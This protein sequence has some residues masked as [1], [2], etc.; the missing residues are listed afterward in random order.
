MAT[1]KPEMLP[2]KNRKKAICSTPNY[3]RCYDQATN[4]PIPTLLEIKE[5]R[6]LLNL[7]AHP[8][9]E[10]RTD[11][12]KKAWNALQ[13]TQGRDVG[14]LRCPECHVTKWGRRKSEPCGNCGENEGGY[15]RKA[16]TEERANGSD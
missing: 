10:N 11:A 13:A 5:G 16:A 8:G 6:A 7:L 2:A 14:L 15:Y 9:D 1:V 4:L 3:H 12:Y